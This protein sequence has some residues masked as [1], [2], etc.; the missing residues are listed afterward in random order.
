MN[1]QPITETHGFKLNRFAARLQYEQ[2]MQRVADEVD[3]EANMIQCLVKIV[4]GRKFAKVDVGSSGK[5]MV[6]NETG[7]IFGIKAYGQVHKGHR[8]GT[9]DTIENFWWGGY[10]AEM[11]THPVAK[12][13]RQAQALKERAIVAVTAKFPAGIPTPSP[14]RREEQV[15]AGADLKVGDKVSVRQYSDIDPGT[16]IE[17]SGS[18]ATVRLHSFKLLNGP[19]SGEPDAMTCTP[20]GFCAHWSGTQRNEVDGA[21]DAGT[22]KI[23]LRG[24]FGDHENVWRSVGADNKNVYGLVYIGWRPHHDYNF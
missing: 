7:E 4:P 20:G 19:T 8:Y 13:A 15:Y 14:R 16:V 2:L 1:N 17:R 3:C 6:D 9:L 5:Y 23:T 22:V 18:T 10:G 21:S 12:F 11:L 24:A